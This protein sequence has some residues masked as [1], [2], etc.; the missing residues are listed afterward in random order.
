L[1]GE[2]GTI[3]SMAAEVPTRRRWLQF[4]L[5]TM[6]LLVTAFAV[7]LGLALGG[8]LTAYD[9]LTTRKWAESRGAIFREGG[10]PVPALRQFLWDQPIESISIHRWAGHADPFIQDEKDRLSHAF[11]EAKVRDVISL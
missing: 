8:G 10:S 1:P 3:A 4:G 9:R 6:L 2:C 5:G 7:L 11:P